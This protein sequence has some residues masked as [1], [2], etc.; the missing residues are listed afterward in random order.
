MNS[1][2][3]VANT[4]ENTDLN[5]KYMRFPAVKAVQGGFTEAEQVESLTNAN[6]AGKRQKLS[7]HGNRNRFRAD[8]CPF[9]FDPAS[10]SS[11]HYKEPPQLKGLLCK[12]PVDLVSCANSLAA[13]LPARKAMT[14]LLPFSAAKSRRESERAILNI[15]TR[16]SCAPRHSISTPSMGGV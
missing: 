10:I 5:D 4:C 3:Q 13:H 2:L 16:A 12:E 8:S 14:P 11:K 15:R 7:A 1:S 9:A 6:N